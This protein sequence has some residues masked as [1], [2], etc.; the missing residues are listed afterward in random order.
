MHQDFYKKKK[1][2][3]SMYYGIACGGKGIWKTMNA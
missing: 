1:G 2:R 3:Y